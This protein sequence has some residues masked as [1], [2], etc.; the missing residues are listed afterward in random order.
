MEDCDICKTIDDACHKTHYTR[1]QGLKSLSELDIKTQ[2]VLL[3]RAGQGSELFNAGSAK[4]CFHHELKFGSVFGR[5]HTKCANI[6]NRYKKKTV[7]G[8]HKITIKM[9]KMLD[10]KDIQL[11]PGI[12]P[13]CSCLKKH[14]H[15]VMMHLQW[16]IMILP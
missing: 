16:K 6:F 5:R 8:G 15:I 4:V 9:A 12:Q 13:C 1:N 3:W 14:K 7:K 10:G 11:V 2:D